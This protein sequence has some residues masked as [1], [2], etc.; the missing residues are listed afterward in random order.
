MKQEFY[1]KDIDGLR[2][3]AVL[4]VVLEHAHI[5]GFSGGFIGV[6]IFFVISG[7]LITGILVR[8]LEEKRF[9]ILNFYERR[10]RRILPALF[11]MMAVT[12]IAGWLLH[13]PQ[14][15][16]ALGK[17][18]VATLAFAS[19]IWFW[20]GAGD[21]FGPNVEFEPLLHTWSLAVEEQFYVFFPL[22]LWAV[23]SLARRKWILCLWVIALM[24][25][26]LSIWMTDTAPTANFYL[27]PTRAWELGAGA[28]LA[29]GAFPQPRKRLWLEIAGGLGLIMIGAS[30]VFLTA[31]TPFPGLAALP[32]VLGTTLFIYAG[33]TRPV[34]A[35]RLLSWQPFVWIGLI[36]YSLYLWHWPVLVVARDLSGTVNLPLPLAGF[37]IGISVVLAWLSWRYV[38]R[39]FRKS[40]GPGTFSGRQIFQL[41]GAGMAILGLCGALIVLRGGIVGQYPQDRLADYQIAT[42]R[43]QI[44]RQC[45]KRT[46]ETPCQIG[47]T[48]TEPSVIFWGD[49]HAGAAL[50]GLEDWLK[51]TDQSALVY[52][53]FACAP[54]WGV[55]R[56]DQAPGHKC[57]HHNAAVLKQIESAPA[58]VTTVILF[59][60]WALMTEG[61][62]AKHEAGGPALLAQ[63]GE[64]GSDIGENAQLV[65]AGLAYVASDITDSG[66]E[67][68]ILEATPEIGNN[69]PGM[70]LRHGEHVPQHLIPSMTEV[71][72]R[73]ARA[74]RILDQLS[75][76]YGVQILSP[77][78]ILCSE[79][80]LV[81]IDGKSLYRDDDHLSTFGAKWLIPQ[82]LDRGQNS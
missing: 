14:R 33:M 44:E 67:L 10:A 80:C 74:D 59:G 78:D 73:H 45:M 5:P 18:V 58:S 27:V 54:I 11:V 60:R 53:K 49:S 24:S 40:S 13:S 30:I 47:A 32:A 57:D 35:G 21:Y 16:E 19:N 6:D 72:T 76:D 17:S 1:R 36:S 62:R 79:A 25:F 64:S 9:S 7:F 28:L 61:T 2:M 75:I 63:R 70:L 48:G 69:V 71:T 46:V 37:C 3:I 50:P 56:A 52:T 31:A 4:P 65:A 77:R 39:P 34:A 68:V 26:C 43:S 38:E 42:Q 22:F 55:Y 51:T 15:F 12:L 20:L 82:V 81:Q 8:E 23:S 29:M 41:S 66:K